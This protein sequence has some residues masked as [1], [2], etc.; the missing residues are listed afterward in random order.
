MKSNYTEVAVVLDRSGSMVS[1]AADMRGGFDEFIAAQRKL[2]GVCKVTLARFDTDYELV[3]SQC[4]VAEVP[5]LELVPRG[6]TALLDA[7][8]RTI[9]ELGTKLA[10]MKEKDR[11][12][13]VMFVV[14]TDGQEN[15]SKE[16]NYER[17]RGMIEHQ[18]AKYNWEFVFLGADANAFEVAASI[19][20]SFHNT[21]NYAASSVG[22]R[23][24][25]RGLSQSLD[26][27]RT[28]GTISASL[29]DTYSMAVADITTETK[30][31]E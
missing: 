22:S 31:K 1:I 9:N 25:F 17:I 7:V 28:N 26:D 11:P 15:S 13:K 10:R 27:L 20:I 21:A 23:A 8:G 14:I 12:A 6:G 29:Q 4:P 5:P 3:Y 30:D 16:Y 24:L 19:G 18:R 2:D